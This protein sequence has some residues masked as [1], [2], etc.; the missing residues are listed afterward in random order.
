[1]LAVQRKSDLDTAIEGDGDSALIGKLDTAVLQTAPPD[2]KVAVIRIILKNGSPLWR[3]ELLWNNLPDSVVEANIGLGQSKWQDHAAVMS[4]H[5]RRKLFEFDVADL[6]DD[7][8]A[9]SLAACE[10]Y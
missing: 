4:N 7:M 5:P 2:K 1:A 6:A 10:A 3:L 9:E 8:L